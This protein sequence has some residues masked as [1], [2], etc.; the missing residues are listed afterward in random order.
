MGNRKLP[1]GYMMQLGDVIL[2]S[3]ECICVRLI[4]ERYQKGAS[5]KEL[6]ELMKDQGVPYDEG[7][8]W[9]KNMI[10]RILENE[11][12]VGQ[13]PYAAI[14]T[15]EQFDAVA[16]MRTGKQ[17]STEQSEAQK[18]LRKICDERITPNIER[19]VLHLLN[20]L[21]EHPELVQSPPEPPHG[22]AKYTLSRKKLDD[23]L[24]QQPIDE[25]LT[26]KLIKELA[27]AE[28]DSVGSAEYE[29]E[30]I[31]RFLLKEEPAEELN[32]AIIQKCVAKIIVSSK[33]IASLRLKNGQI[34]ERS[35]LQ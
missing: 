34:I 6:V 21:V 11:R 22:N 27:S 20:D 8:L 24:A 1:F 31:Q 29:T 33:R 5:F 7:K 30:R 18:A 19:Q 28:Y 2:H 3:E 16:A 14:I 9:N 23:A 13:S 17:L 25:V 32:G 12:Y 15:K 10:A 4:F 35:T 26:R